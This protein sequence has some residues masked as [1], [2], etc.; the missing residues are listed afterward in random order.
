MRRNAKTYIYSVVPTSKHNYKVN[1]K[2]SM[3]LFL[4]VDKMKNYCLNNFPIIIILQENATALFFLLCIKT[5]LGLRSEF[6]L[7]TLKS[8]NWTGARDIRW[9]IVAPNK[10]NNAA[11]TCNGP[12]GLIIPEITILGQ[13]IVQATGS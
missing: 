6:F 2:T 11:S 1:K 8:F 9:R 3:S 4:V 7:R 10:K 12:A 5:V 13:G